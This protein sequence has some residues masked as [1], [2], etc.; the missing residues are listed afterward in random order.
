MHT[1]KKKKIIVDVLMIL[2]MFFSMGL[3][4]FGPGVHKM[5]GL[6]TFLLFFVHNLLNRKWYRGLRKGKYSPTRLAHTVTNFGV[7]LAM[8]GVMV[9]GVMLSKEMAQGLD[10]MTIGRILHNASSYAGCIGIAMH[11]GFHLKR[12]NHH[13]D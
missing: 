5:I 4:M 12:S 10:G 13:D 8:I 6:L 9:S 3:Q 1:T 7:I 11:I 2:G